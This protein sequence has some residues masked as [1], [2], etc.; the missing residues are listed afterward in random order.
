[1]GNK[2]RRVLQTAFAFTLFVSSF[3]TLAQDAVT[4]RHQGDGYAAKSDYASAAPLLARSAELGL[5]PA[6]I[7]YAVL[8]D[9]SPPPVNDNIKAFAWYSLVIARKG[10]DTG[11]AEQRL[12]LVGNRLTP[13]ESCQAKQLASQLISKYGQPAER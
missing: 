8:L 12:A 2:M 5:Y 7:D 4:L 11:F 3:C 6:Q 13:A 1:M 10:S 9:T